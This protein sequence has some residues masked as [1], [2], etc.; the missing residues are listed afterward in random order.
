MFITIP[1]CGCVF[2]VLIS[3]Q[4]IRLTYYAFDKIDEIL[5][6]LASYQCTRSIS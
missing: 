1:C 5:I 2:I 3:Y 4:S 6:E